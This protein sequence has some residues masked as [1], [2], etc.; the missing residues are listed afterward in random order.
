MSREIQSEPAIQV[1]SPNLKNYAFLIFELRHARIPNGRVLGIGS[2]VMPTTSD[3]LR[4][5]SA[6]PT[7][8][9]LVIRK[10]AILIPLILSPYF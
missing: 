3:A 5:F 7:K 2:T 4:K 8:S 10:P 9:I 1:H 6:V